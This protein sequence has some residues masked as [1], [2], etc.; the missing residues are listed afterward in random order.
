MTEKII[1]KTPE[2]IVS[3]TSQIRGPIA[4]Y[5]FITCEHVPVDSTSQSILLQLLAR[6]DTEIKVMVAGDRKEEKLD[7]GLELYN[8]LTNTM[9]RELVNSCFCGL[10]GP[11]RLMIGI[12]RR[13]GINSSCA[14][15]MEFP[16]IVLRE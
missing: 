14:D 6:M 8:N 1:S 15:L 10:E 5:W 16:D 3:S 7:I 13:K 11:G 4:S 9:I 12:S 2:N